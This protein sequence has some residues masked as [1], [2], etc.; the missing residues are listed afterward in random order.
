MSHLFGSST[1][2]LRVTSSKR[3]Y[4]TRWVSQVCCSQSLCPRGRSL[5]TR[6]STGDTQT[7][8]GKSGSVSVGASRSWCTQC[9][10]WAIWAL[11]V[12]MMFDS[13]FDF[14]PPTVLLGL[15]RCPWTWGI[16]FWLD[17]TF[18]CRWLFSSEV[19]LWSS[20]RRWAHILLLCHL[21]SWLYTVTLLI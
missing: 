5:L 21:V 3:A 17:P 18:C 6:A 2:G 7:L 12:G 10:V 14:T 16:F 8:K 13:K 1:V 9:F 19:Q 11:L 15:F 20:H 4:V